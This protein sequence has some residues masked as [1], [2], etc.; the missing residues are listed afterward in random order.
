LTNDNPRGEDPERIV[1]DIRTGIGRA[2]EVLLDRRAAIEFA[3]REAA[4]GDTVL[5]AGKGH[6]EYQETAGQ[7]EAFSDVTEAEAV[8]ARRSND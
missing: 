6:E 7:R 1:R 5:I 8:L 3:I 4:P 2:S